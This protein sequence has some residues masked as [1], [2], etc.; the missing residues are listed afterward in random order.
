MIG[1]SLAK[2]FG[3]AGRVMSVEC[4]TDCIV[5]HGL[6]WNERRIPNER[7]VA[8]TSYPTIIYC[9]PS[10]RIRR[11][12][13][14]YLAP[15]R[16]GDPNRVQRHGLQVQVD[17]AIRSTMRDY[18]RKAAHLDDQAL[19]DRLRTAQAAERWTSRNRRA[20]RSGADSLWAKHVSL[21]EAEHS[22]RGVQA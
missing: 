3:S 13:I 1:G 6:W 18:K 14:G 22:R 4:G 5:V 11:K 15:N 2:R 10:G 20:R 21:L 16:Y 9:S 12:R 7:I 8:I 19:A 17:Q